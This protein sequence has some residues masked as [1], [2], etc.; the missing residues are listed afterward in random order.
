M[1]KINSSTLKAL[2]VL[3]LL[4]G[5]E[6]GLRLTDVAVSLGF[7]TS[8]ARR[9]LA[10]LLDRGYVEQD[11]Q[12]SR[13]YLG[14]KILTLQARGFRHRQVIRLAYPYLKQLQRELDE[15]VNLGI[16]AD[17]GV[18]YVETLAPESSFAFYA[19][20]G[21]RMPLFCPALGKLF[22][23]H[24][25]ETALTAALQE[26]DWKRRTPQTMTTPEELAARLPEIRTRGYAIDH[27]EYAAGVRC[28]AAPVLSHTGEPVAAISVTALASRQT[29][30]RETA[31][32]RAVTASCARISESLGYAKPRLNAGSER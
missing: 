24:L 18:T 1:A 26:I 20:P 4:A 30:E 7:P 8:T 22:L 29:G 19:P 5:E 10:S 32:A 12:T 14:A 2:D 31:V 21:T 28:V 3:E 11:A 9:L 6:S 17:R 16:L 25:S 27:V 23:A 15:T 13:Y